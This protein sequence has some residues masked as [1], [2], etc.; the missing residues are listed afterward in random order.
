MKVS[1][2]HLQ[3]NSGTCRYGNELCWFKHENNNGVNDNGNY[4]QEV[5]DKIFNMMEKITE[6][7]LIMENEVKV[8]LFQ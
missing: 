3:Q 5:F 8:K 7:V 4:Q 6:R 2:V 1:R